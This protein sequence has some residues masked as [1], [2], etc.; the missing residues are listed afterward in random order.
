MKK[1]YNYSIKNS[2]F[3][4]KKATLKGKNY[5]VCLNYYHV[6]VVKNIRTVAVE[7]N[8]T[9]GL[10]GFTKTQNMHNCAFR[11]KLDTNAKICKALIYKAKLIF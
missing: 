11:Y 6:A 3:E 8:N 4:I 7:T 9:N 5:L 10:R 1:N 2:T